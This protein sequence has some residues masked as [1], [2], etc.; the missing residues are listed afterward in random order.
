M[1][2]NKHL[3]STALSL[4]TYIRGSDEETRAIRPYIRGSD[5]ETR[6]I[7]RTIIRYLVLSQT[8]VLRNVSVQVRRRFPTFEAIE[9]ADL[10]TPEERAIIEET[11][12]EYSQFWIPIL[13]AQQI[14]CDANQQGKIS[15]DFIADKIATNIE[16]FRSQLQN[17][18]KFDWVPI[19]LVYPQL[20]DWVPIPLVYPQLV[21]FCVR[22]Y[23]FICLFTRQIIKSDDIGLPE[24]P[25]FWIPLT[26]IIEFVVYMGWLKVAEDM[27]H[28][29]GEDSD[30]LECNYIIDKNLITGLSIVDRGGKP[31]PPPKKDAFWDKQN[32]APL[33]SF[34]TAHRTVTPMT[35]SAANVKY[36]F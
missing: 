20:F 9:A 16:N 22:L 21:T 23:F 6:A 30:N 35:G 33:Y 7:R 12:D 28:P 24:S 13:W 10:I 11:S 3:F 26:T 18:L 34:N 4:A 1:L 36:D 8:C 14:L 25:L 5:E 2:R 32:L 17:L 19:P 15:S 29:L 31:F 27:L